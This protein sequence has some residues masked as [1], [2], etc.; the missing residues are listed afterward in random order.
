MGT[1]S[2]QHASTNPK[3][4]SPPPPVAVRS[5]HPYVPPM[6]LRRRVPSVIHGPTG[7]AFA[8]PKQNV[9]PPWPGRWTYA[10][11]IPCLILA[12][13]SRPHPTHMHNPPYF[14]HPTM[15]LAPSLPRSSLRWW[16]ARCPRTRA[17]RPRTRRRCSSCSPSY[18]TCWKCPTRSSGWAADPATE[19]GRCRC[20]EEEGGREGW[21]DEAA[22][23]GCCRCE[24]EDY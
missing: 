2:L 8:C 15:L 23:T 16:Q 4:W 24:G 7:V 6:Q 18:A 21:A 3:L 5:V 11:L 14:P 9:A 19:T 1:C 17:C 10:P 22:G 13:V 12:A 20:E